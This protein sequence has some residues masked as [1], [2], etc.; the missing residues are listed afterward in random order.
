VVVLLV[1]LDEGK[2]STPD[3]INTAVIKMSGITT[4]ITCVLR[5]IIFHYHES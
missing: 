4:E 3:V 1:A 2:I 5:V